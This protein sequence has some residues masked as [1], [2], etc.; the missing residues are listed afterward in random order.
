MLRANPLK[1]RLNPVFSTIGVLAVCCL[2]FSL[3]M[4]Y[5][6]GLEPCGLCLA[7]RHIYEGLLLSVLLWYYLKPKQVFQ[8]IVI[9]LLITGIIVASYHT[10]TYFDLIE[11]KCNIEQPIPSFQA[12]Y[13]NLSKTTPPP[14]CSGQMMKVLGIPLPMANIFIY[15]SC[16]LLI[17]WRRSETHSQ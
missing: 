7:Q 9:L 12:Y 11:T 2:G 8:L 16:L 1:G 17:F 15:T 3:V 13:S 5:W 10:L 6:V 14:S 4:Q